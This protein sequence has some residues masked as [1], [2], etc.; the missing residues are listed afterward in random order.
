MKKWYQSK[1]IWYAII[2]GSAIVVTALATN[3][4]EVALF[5]V[6]NTAI[7]IALRLITTEPIR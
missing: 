1:Q 7:Q 6:L 3:Y 2:S 5:G 4:P